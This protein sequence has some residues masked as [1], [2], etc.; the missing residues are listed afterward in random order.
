M[1]VV[2]FLVVGQGLAG[3][4]LA[5]TLR[6]NGASVVIIDA[7]EMTTASKVAAG[8]IHPI[9][10][11][12]MVKSWRIDELLPF[13]AQTYQALEARFEIVFFR[14]INVVRLL[15]S[16]EE[17]N[18]WTLRSAWADYAPYCA[19]TPPQPP[20]RGSSHLG[21]SP[22]WG[23]GGAWSH[24]RKT[25]EIKSAQVQI[26]LL[27]QSFRQAFLAEQIL[28]FD[29]FD[30]DKLTIYENHV[31]Y[32]G[33]IQAKKII[34]CEGANAVNNPFFN[35]LPITPDKG[36]LQIIRPRETV[37]MDKILKMNHLAIVPQPNID[38]LWVGATH[39]RDPKHPQPT[40]TM[41]DSI[42]AAL[43]EHFV[44]PYDL[45]RSDAAVRAT[46][47][48]RRPIL[49]FHRYFPTLAIF[50]GFGAKGASLVPF[51]AAHF[52]EVLLG[53]TDLDAEVDLKRFL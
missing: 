8:V 38:T 13:A 23:A 35:F 14:Y 37:T 7:D 36:E 30:H 12:R 25:A 18:E 31:V 33:W 19:T 20:K 32:D 46:T 42:S 50:N 16:I 26:K 39:E 51:W 44:A 45:V 17:E 43:D 1:K 15:H 41:Q 2:D 24:E 9:T 40:Q 21:N 4:L 3:S 10:G 49:G 6:T 48:D 22:F 53:K 34:F 52:A 11:R 29:Q 27:L 28:H 47:R 5:D